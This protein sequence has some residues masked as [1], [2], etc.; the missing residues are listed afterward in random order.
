[1][2]FHYIKYKNIIIVIFI[3][4]VKAWLKTGCFKLKLK[5]GCP[6]LWHHN[7]Y[8]FSHGYILLILNLH[9]TNSTHTI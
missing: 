6:A 2:I 3:N 5:N 4:N 7:F 8:E 9:L 1:M